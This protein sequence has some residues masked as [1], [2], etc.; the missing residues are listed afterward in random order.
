MRRSES[1]LNNY[2]KERGGGCYIET[3][4]WSVES[5][6]KTYIKGVAEDMD[7]QINAICNKFDKV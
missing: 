3:F 2:R 5:L 1:I 6:L 7:L 4:I